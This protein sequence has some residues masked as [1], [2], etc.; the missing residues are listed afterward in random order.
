[1]R[2]K[3]GGLAKPKPHVAG[4]P[5]SCGIFLF[6][7]DTISTSRVIDMKEKIPKTK[8]KESG[9]DM[10]A[11][12][13]KQGFDSVDKRFDGVD[14]RLDGVDER[15]DSLEKGQ[16]SLE[17]GQN[18]LVQEVLA[19]NQAQEETNRRLTSIERKQIGILSSLDE[20]V[21]RKEF[22][23]LVSKVAVL[24]KRR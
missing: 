21:T 13:M 8:N 14:K 7:C 5:T 9:I 12:M 20:T 11:R 16:K 4:Y 18:S 24:E 10:L 6:V 3:R 2:A 17:A 19:L 23:V 22:Q 15:L 1:M